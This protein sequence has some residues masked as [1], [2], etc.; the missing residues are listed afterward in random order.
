MK[1]VQNQEI[2]VLS[3]I[4]FFTNFVKKYLILLLA[5]TVLGILGGFA[6]YFF[7]KEVYKTKIVASSPIINSRIVYELFEPVKHYVLRGNNDSVANQL[8]ISAEAAGNIKKIIFD[9]TVSQAVIVNFEVYSKNNINEISDGL[10]YYLNN[11]DYVKK[12]IENTKFKLSSYLDDLNREID[13]LEKL[14]QAILNNVEN[15]S[16]SN[17]SISNTYNEMLMLY[18]RRN[19]IENELSRIEAF[20]IVKGNFVF[21]SSKSIVKSVLVFLFLGM[22]LGFGFASFVEVKRKLKQLTNR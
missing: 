15:N 3:L 4:K 12:Y 13:K 22:F 5:F 14:Q 17:V 19:D 9:T 20:K 8:N 11:L 2:S 7:S 21:E 1:D 10:I 18:D 6:H 16:S